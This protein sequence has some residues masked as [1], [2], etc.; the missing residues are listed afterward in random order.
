MLKSY[1]LL[2]A[3]KLYLDDKVYILLN[4]ISKYKKNNTVG[5]F[6]DYILELSLTKVVVN[7]KLRVFFV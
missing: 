6:K 4:I 3:D 5:I 7:L 2:E 1:D